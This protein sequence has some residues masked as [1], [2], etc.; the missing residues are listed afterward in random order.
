MH[1]ALYVGLFTLGLFVCLL[2]SLELGRRYGARQRLG[3]PDLPERG[4]GTVEAAVFGLLGLLIAFT[5]SG[6][7]TRDR[8]SVV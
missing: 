1:H 2:L 3:N 5:F 6:A 7:A 4:S 8:K